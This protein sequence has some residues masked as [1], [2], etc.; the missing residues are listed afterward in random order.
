AS[1]RSHGASRRGPSSASGRYREAPA[2]AC[3][4]AAKRRAAALTAAASSPGLYSAEPSPNPFAPAA[5]YGAI[6]S[7][8]MPPTGS[9]Q[10]SALSTARSA[11]TPAGGISSAGNSLSPAAPAASAANASVGVSTP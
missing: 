7:G 1:R 4:A 2:N 11:F 10:V 9:T 3:H 6:V 8:V 5:R